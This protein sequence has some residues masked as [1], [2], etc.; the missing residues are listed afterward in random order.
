MHFADVDEETK[1]HLYGQKHVPK[2]LWSSVGGKEAPYLDAVG[3]GIPYCTECFD[4]V[5]VEMLSSEGCLLLTHH[6]GVEME[7]FHLHQIHCIRTRLGMALQDQYFDEDSHKA[8]LQY[9]FSS[10]F[11]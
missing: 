8:P 5:S 7:Y 1:K 9:L 11:A 4:G 2:Y 6:L 3:Y 10:L